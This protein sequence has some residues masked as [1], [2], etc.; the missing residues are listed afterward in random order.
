M[1]QFRVILAVTAALGLGACNPWFDYRPKSV[2]EE[3]VAATNGR[4]ET[5]PS[6]TCPAK[7]MQHLV[8]QAVTVL[9]TIRFGTEVRVE[10]PGEMHTQEF[11]P[12]RTRIIVGA[13]GRIAHVL[14][15]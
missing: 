4:G 5:P 3:T 12:T 7:D 2:G 13:N 1:M 15:G 6:Q 10:V 14:C 8:G 9:E 11:K